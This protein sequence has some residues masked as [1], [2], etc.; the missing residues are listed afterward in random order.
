ML[1]RIWKI[2]D[3]TKFF[4]LGKNFYLFCKISSFREHFEK[5][6]EIIAE[7][8]NYYKLGKAKQTRQA[9]F[10]E[11]V[12]YYYVNKSKLI[13]QGNL[14]N[15]IILILWGSFLRF[16]KRKNFFSFIF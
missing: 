1:H 2:T 11:C 8:T 13:R 15:F 4:K 6:A 14:P 3:F 5:Y 9:H 16:S 12:K 10:A 7:F